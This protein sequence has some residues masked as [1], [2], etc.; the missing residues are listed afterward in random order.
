MTTN[1]VD[2]HAPRANL[3]RLLNSG[4]AIG[5]V[6]AVEGR[7]GEYVVHGA[8]VA[9]LASLARAPSRQ[10]AEQERLSGLADMCIKVLGPDVAAPGGTCP[11]LCSGLE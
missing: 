9:F 11:A 10:D 4:M 6:D 5:A 8:M 1:N 7:N 3:Q 2:R